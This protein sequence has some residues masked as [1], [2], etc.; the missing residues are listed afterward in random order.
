[1]NIPHLHNIIA[2]TTAIHGVSDNGDGSY[3]VDLLDGTTRLATA[4]EILTATQATKIEAINAEVRA[5]LIAR[6]GTAEEQV[7]RALGIYGVAEQTAMTAGIAA[8]ID[9]SNAAQN[10]ILAATD[11]ATVE[12]VAVTW[13]VI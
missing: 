3:R 4:A 1:M 2:A 12:A 5:R 13:P 9:A 6:Y 8:T 10:A 7:S 11:T